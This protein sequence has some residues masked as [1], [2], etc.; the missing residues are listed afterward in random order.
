MSVRVVATLLLAVAATVHAS[1][2]SVVVTLEDTPSQNAS[3][4]WKFRPGS[5]PQDSD[6]QGDQ[7]RDKFIT[8]SEKRLG[9]A[10]DAIAIEALMPSS[11][12]LTIRWLSRSVV[13]VSADC[14]F[15]AHSKVR[16]RCL[17]VLEKHRS[18]WNVTHHYRYSHPFTSSV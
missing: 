7:W 5:I 3:H 14:C 4:H 12:P 15:D 1:D 17:Y 13:L 8:A 2:N 16:L 18:K 9:S 6:S 10:K 11:M